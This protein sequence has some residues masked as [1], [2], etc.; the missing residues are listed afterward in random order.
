MIQ[1]LKGLEYIFQ[2]WCVF[3]SKLMFNS[4]GLTATKSE[5]SIA[6]RLYSSDLAK[7]IMVFHTGNNI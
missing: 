6:K 7:D 1:K 3:P 5:A 2:I 4:F